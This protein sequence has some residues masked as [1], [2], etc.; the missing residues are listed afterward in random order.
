MLMIVS[1]IL[2]IVGAIA[3]VDG[4]TSIV[5]IHLDSKYGLYEFGLA[6]LIVGSLCL[7]LL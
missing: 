7:C 2:M 4:Y 1:V 6:T 5:A 3:T